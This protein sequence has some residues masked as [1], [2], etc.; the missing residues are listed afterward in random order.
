MTAR[1]KTT[2]TSGDTAPD[3]VAT[4][5]VDEL[6]GDA[7]VNPAKRQIALDRHTSQVRAAGGPVEPDFYTRQFVHPARVR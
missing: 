7:K 5:Q 6:I 2:A 4:E 1:R 3:K